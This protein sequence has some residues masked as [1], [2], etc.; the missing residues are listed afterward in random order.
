MRRAVDGGKEGQV[1]AYDA[2]FC[3]LQTAQ[4]PCSHLQ[5]AVKALGKASW[6]GTEGMMTEWMVGVVPSLGL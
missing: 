5:T 4:G 6:P 2:A 1:V 3:R